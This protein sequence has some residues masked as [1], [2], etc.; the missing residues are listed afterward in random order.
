MLNDLRY[1]I[2]ML[3]KS[4]GFTA[5]AVLT[6]AL[7]IGAN[8]AI[9]S[10]VDSVML[11]PLPYS[12]PDRIIHFFWGWKNG[13]I[14]AITPLEYQYWKEQNRSFESVATYGVGTGL[15]LA[16]QGQAEY[17][18]GGSVSQDFFKVLRVSPMLGRV[19]TAE[20]DS[21]HGP[22]V[23]ILSHGLW[24]SHFASDPGLV[25]RPITINGNHYTVVGI[26]PADFRFV[27]PY[28][29]TIDVWLPMQLEVNSEDQGH[30]YPV[31]GRLR[32]DVT[33]AQ[34]Q[35]DAARLF[36]PFRAE[37]PKHLG[38]GERGVQLMTYGQYVARDTRRYLLLLLGV[39]G[40]VFLIA[41]GN[42][43]NLLLSRAVVRQAEISVRLVLGASGWRVVRQFTAE[44]LLVSL[45]GGVA[46]LGLAPWVLERPAS[47]CA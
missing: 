35:A 11:R 38:E 25:G 17:V 8:A 29:R 3:L 36:A 23:C 1:A 32:P 10:L 42:V 15:N 26:L 28:S 33:L 27:P 7:G 18:L 2:R 34:A 19:F 43:L 41:V 40:V 14:D 5:V 16:S 37:Y 22:R 30:N 4:P 12:E 31:I 46:G 20:E 24:H 21:A 47:V 13:S 6:L 45:I 39:V 44:A 9:F